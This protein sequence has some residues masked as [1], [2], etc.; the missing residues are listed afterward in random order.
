MT[1]QAKTLD[2]LRAIQRPTREIAIDLCRSYYADI[3]RLREKIEFRRQQSN[4]FAHRDL[5]WDCHDKERRWE[6]EIDA[7]MAKFEITAEE[8]GGGFLEDE[9][10]LWEAG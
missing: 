9:R 4:Y 8:I 1:I 7:L 5:I 6:R 2:E 3:E 10:A